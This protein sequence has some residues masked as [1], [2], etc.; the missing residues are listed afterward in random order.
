MDLIASDSDEEK[1]EK[2]DGSGAGKC[3]TTGPAAGNNGGIG[4]GMEGK[5]EGEGGDDWQSCERTHTHTHTHTHTGSTYEHVTL[6]ALHMARCVL[7]NS[8][9]TL[10]CC[11]RPLV[12]VQP[13][14]ACVTHTAALQ[15]ATHKARYSEVETG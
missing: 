13:V 14:C 6:C 1:S 9:D 8:C 15:K 11:V 12:T 4:Q 5:A 3:D 2:S 7:C 10:A